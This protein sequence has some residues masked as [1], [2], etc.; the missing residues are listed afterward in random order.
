MKFQTARPFFEKP[1]QMPCNDGFSDSPENAKRC[2]E[3]HNIAHQCS[4][5]TEQLEFV[6][7]FQVRERA[8]RLFINET[9]RRI[10]FRDARC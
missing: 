8:A 3:F 5:G 9:M 10:E 7:V 6:R 4:I 1:P 2:R